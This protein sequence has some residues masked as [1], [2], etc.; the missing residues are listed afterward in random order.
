MSSDISSSDIDAEI[1]FIR[2]EILPHTAWSLGLNLALAS[3]GCPKIYYYPAT[4]SLNVACD[5]L[6][7]LENLHNIY[8]SY[9]ISLLHTVRTLNIDYYLQ[10]NNMVLFSASK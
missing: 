7:S 5:Q 6:N 3:Y 9:S 2:S 1:D 10:I 8:G 4:P